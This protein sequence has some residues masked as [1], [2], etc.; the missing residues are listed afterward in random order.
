MGGLPRRWKRVQE[1]HPG[2]RNGKERVQF[3][4]GRMHDERRTVKAALKGWILE[5]E[6]GWSARE[7][8]GRREGCGEA[9]MADEG[10]DAVYFGTMSDG[11]AKSCY[12]HDANAKRAEWL[13]EEGAEGVLTYAHGTASRYRCGS[14][15]V[16][17]AI[18]V[19]IQ[20]LYSAFDISGHETVVY[21][22]LRAKDSRFTDN[23]AWYRT[24]SSPGEPHEGGEGEKGPGHPEH[25][26]PELEAE[27]MTGRE[28]HGAGGVDLRRV[29]VYLHSRK[30]RRTTET[31]TGRDAHAEPGYDRDQEPHAVRSGA[32]VI[33]GDIRHHVDGGV[34]QHGEER[35]PEAVSQQVAIGTLWRCL[36]TGFLDDRVHQHPASQDQGPLTTAP[37]TATRTTSHRRRR[38]ARLAVRSHADAPELAGDDHASFQFEKP[39]RQP[40]IAVHQ[41]DKTVLN[42]FSGK[43]KP[44]SDALSLGQRVELMKR[45][46]N[47]IKKYDS[48][49]RIMHGT[50]VPFPMPEVTIYGSGVILFAI[51]IVYDAALQ[52]PRDSR[53]GAPYPGPAQE[54]VRGRGDGRGAD[55]RDPGLLGE[56]LSETYRSAEVDDGQ[57]GV[58]VLGDGVGN[59][60][61]E[62]LRLRD[63]SGERLHGVAFALCGVKIL[64][65]IKPDRK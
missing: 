17:E 45:A 10:V 34:G 5:S 18:F 39:R 59:A 49:N 47:V 40:M 29:S 56:R 63:V 22:E 27:E 15:E 6:S 36:P 60:D 51:A 25:R 42:D 11:G 44:V 3:G 30:I 9:G 2:A 55:P 54:G 31:R 1:G 32:A 48:C 19:E 12:F 26:A 7:R 46:Q 21:D 4:C 28:P 14:E 58:R 37:R 52:D 35:D 50:A 24:P 33:R 64:R 20:S 8:G 38:A 62:P 16:A 65:I 13:K 53:S 23:E 41:K 43:D 57:H 61:H